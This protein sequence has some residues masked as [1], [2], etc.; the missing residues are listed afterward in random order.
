MKDSGDKNQ[1]MITYFLGFIVSVIIVVILITFKDFLVPITIAIL[2]TYLFHPVLEYLKVK[3]KIPRPIGVIFI[4]ILNFALFYVL[5]LIFF[6]S[7]GD[8]SAR[9]QYYGDK[10]SAIVIDILRPFNLTLLELE[11]WLGYETQ[12][13]DAGQLLK[14]LFDAGII[15]GLFSSFSNLL[16]N[17]FLVMLFW[18][19][20]ILGK[21]QFEKRLKVAFA[22]SSFDT[23]KQ[24]NAVSDQLQS[25]LMIKTL[26]SLATGVTFTVVLTIYG[27]DFAMIWGLLAFILNYIPNIGSLLATIFP[28][29]IAMLDLGFGFASVSLAVILFAVQNIYGNIIEPK[30]MGMKLDLSPVFILMSLIFWGWI[31]GIVG[32][33][34]AVPIASVLKILCSNVDALKPV[35]ILIGTKAEPL[36]DV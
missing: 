11:S 17:F 5:G 1:R 21:P 15:Q 35:A 2:L 12:K 14:K 10:L 19:F 23:E 34:L 20:M 13:F 18:V 6:A 36:G 30:F 22:S 27:I 24:I 26:I 32:M 7:F 9:I 31:W 16:S 33:F 25:Y 4:L 3:L 28:I 29:I 8:F